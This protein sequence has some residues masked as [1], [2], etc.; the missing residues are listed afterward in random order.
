MES[1]LDRK[2]LVVT[3]KGGVGKTTIAAAIGLLAARRGLRTIVVEVGDHG[4]IGELFTLG[5][6]RP[7][8]ET[9]LQEGLSSITIDPDRVLLEWV[10]ELGGR[11]PGRVLASSG[12]FQYFAAAAP[13][14]KELFGMVKVWELTQ[15]RRWQR[16]AA[17]YDLVV[18]DA[19]ATGHALGMLRS[20]QTFGAIARVGPVASQ[21][22]QVRELLEDPSRSGYLAVALGSEM[23]VT[24]TI[25]LQEGLR[26]QLGRELDAVV[27]NA[28]LP[29]R[30]TP[31]E[32]GRIA[33]LDGN[34]RGKGRREGAAKV[35]EGGKPDGRT[36]DG[37][38]RHAA[39]LAARAVHERGRLQHNQLMR[40]RRRHFDVVGVPFMWRAE[41]D[42]EYL[43]TIADRLSRKL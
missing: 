35:R 32:L 17:G 6:G 16:R 36:E 34:G 30:F 25:E 22:R 20:P 33:A 10:Q 1:L 23:A 21:A 27:M 5:T 11:V 41:L 8:V 2:L 9:R 18:L 15:P 43:E 40:L 3:G 42:L 39:A 14:A 37:E 24:E 29:R 7:G 12:T 31:S 19:P 4:R 13:G 28:L 38:L 26:S